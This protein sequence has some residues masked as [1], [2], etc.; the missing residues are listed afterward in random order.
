MNYEAWN[1][2]EK[3]QA[4]RVR[5]RRDVLGGLVKAGAE[6]LA[7]HKIRIFIQD[8]KDATKCARFDVGRDMF[9]LFFEELEPKKAPPAHV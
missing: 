7:Y 8:P 5:A 2:D 9:D 3:S 6:L 1:Q 4:R